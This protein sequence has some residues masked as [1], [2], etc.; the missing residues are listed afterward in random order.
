[1]RKRAGRNTC[2]V[3]THKIPPAVQSHKSDRSSTM[4]NT[5]LLDQTLHLDRP[6]SR[7]AAARILVSPRAAAPSPRGCYSRGDSRGG[8]R[9]GAD[10]ERPKGILP[11]AP[12]T[13]QSRFSEHRGGVASRS[14]APA[15]IG[16]RTRFIDVPFS[17]FR[18][19]WHLP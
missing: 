1:M 15:V 17:S 10:T 3:P 9:G 12:P 2:N 11:P 6:P 5:I 18:E 4:L 13:A 16:T 19:G 14:A 7:S 8:P